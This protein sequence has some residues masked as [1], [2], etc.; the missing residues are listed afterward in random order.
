[1]VGQTGVHLVE[2]SEASV[3]VVGFIHIQPCVSHHRKVSELQVV[4]AN[5]H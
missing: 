2:F 1:M 5:R 3:W 4:V